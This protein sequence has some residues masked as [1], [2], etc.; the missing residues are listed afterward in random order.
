MFNKRPICSPGVKRLY[1]E[2]DLK[3]SAIIYT[4]FNLEGH[5][6]RM[7]EKHPGWTFKQ[8]NNVLYWQGK[9]RKNLRTFV[10]KVH[11]EYRNIHRITYCHAACD[12][13]CPY[14]ILKLW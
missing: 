10:N 3:R 7:A 11:N 13:N 6:Q 9:A 12:Y 1:D 2:F 8:L 4:E 5:R 14:G